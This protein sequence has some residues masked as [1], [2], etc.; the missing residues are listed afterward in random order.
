MNVLMESYDLLLAPTMAV[1]AF[2][3]G[4]RPDR[5]GGREVDPDWGFN[6]LNI[7]ANVT[8][9]PAASV[10]CGFS[11]DGLP[12]GM[13]IVGRRGGGSHGAAGVRGVREGAPVGRQPPARV[14]VPCVQTESRAAT[15][16]RRLG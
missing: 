12:I 1:P 11:P 2:P 6:P 5:I 15:V 14:V 7:V 16:G 10:P 9:R 8:R 4:T 3:I 13:Q